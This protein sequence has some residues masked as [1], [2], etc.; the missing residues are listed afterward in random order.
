MEAHS[1]AS[2]GIPKWRIGVSAGGLVLLVAVGLGAA[3]AAIAPGSVD[4]AAP[5]DVARAVVSDVAGSASNGDAGLLRPRRLGRALVHATVTL[6]L[7]RT[8]LVTVQLDHGAIS[9]IAGGSLKLLETGNSS[10]TIAGD[11]KTR[12]RKNGAQAK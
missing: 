2:P 5:A 12:V 4:E 11:D 10:V 1:V 7:P 3:N 8:G 6:D 9:A